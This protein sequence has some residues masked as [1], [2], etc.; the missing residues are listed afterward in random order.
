VSDLN[1]EQEIQEM[2][3]LLD[4]SESLRNMPKEGL[5]EFHARALSL[6]G[7]T[8]NEAMIPKLMG[9]YGRLSEVTTPEDR[10]SLLLWLADQIDEG[11]F[12]GNALYPFVLLDSDLAVVSTSTIRFAAAGILNG[13][14]LARV[15]EAIQFMETSNLPGGILGGLQSMGDVR[16]LDLLAEAEEQLPNEQIAAAARCSSG[17]PSM[18]SI[19]F[20]IRSLE[21]WADYMD[22]AKDAGSFQYVEERLG[23]LASGLSHVLTTAQVPFV[24]DSDRIFGFPWLDPKPFP[25]RHRAELAVR[26][27]AGIYA[28][29]LY[30]L[31]ERE[32]RPPF[33][34]PHV[35][36]VFGLRSNRDPSEWSSLPPG[37]EKVI[38][39]AEERAA[40][41][42]NS[43]RS[44][45]LREELALLKVAVAVSREIDYPTPIKVWSGQG[46]EGPQLYLSAEGVGLLMVA[47]P[48]RV[49]ESN[50]S[51]LERAV[52]GEMLSTC[53]GDALE[54]A[55]PP[56]R[57]EE[58]LRQ[59]K[60][61]SSE[62]FPDTPSPS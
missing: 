48:E 62:H 31:D 21:R 7:F 47:E 51:W 1:F 6:Y 28:A 34:F 38:V 42:W 3:V 53:L 25:I 52:K 54:K 14:P 27:A 60:V 8:C 45:T 19:E 39:Q 35:L 57:R 12:H 36:R 2:T 16:L 11:K 5:L 40:E 18:G 24:L 50:R 13:E 33:D 26:Q 32:K 46:P 20:W 55:I 30:R 23:Y 10:V 9:S 29:R 22:R 37:A 44:E 43:A 41:S 4:D 15:R 56:H 59:F 61:L 49:A 58:F 17:F